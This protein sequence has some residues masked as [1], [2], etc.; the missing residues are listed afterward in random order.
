MELT[1]RLSY[2]TYLIIGILFIIAGLALDETS[3]YSTVDS[4]DFNQWYDFLGPWL[5]G[6][7]KGS[8]PVPW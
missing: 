3:I 7:G 4:Y 5:G 2:L 6:D 8:L 1:K